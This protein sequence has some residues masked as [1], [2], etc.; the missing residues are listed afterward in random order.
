MHTVSSPPSKRISELAV[1]P[2]FF[3]LRGKRVVVI[4]GDEPAAWKIEL[5]AAAGAQVDV[6]AEEVCEEL[7]AFLAAPSSGPSG[8]L[9]PDGEKKGSAH[10]SIPLPIGERVDRA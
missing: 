6:F 3:D 7:S 10:A 8:H 2:V 1:L 5:L 9:L 4:G